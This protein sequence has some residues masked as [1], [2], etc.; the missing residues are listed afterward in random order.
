MKLFGGSASLPALPGLPRNVL[1][2]GGPRGAPGSCS[3]T[4]TL[5]TM[6]MTP[7][8]SQPCLGSPFV[9]LCSCTP[10]FAPC[11]KA[12]AGKLF[13]WLPK[14]PFSQPLL[15]CGRSLDLSGRH[16]SVEVPTSVLKSHLMSLQKLPLCLRKMKT[17]SRRWQ[18]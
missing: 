10:E 11:L 5:I 12:R 18:G 14:R 6:E 8:Q 15:L 7:C 17:H 1:G 2:Q 3:C 13:F 4:A 16:S 9:P